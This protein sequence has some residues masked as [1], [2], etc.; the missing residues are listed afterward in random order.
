MNTSNVTA[1]APKVAGA[2]YV[3]PLGTELPKKA[4]T[5]LAPQFKELGYVSDSGMTN[6]NSPSST[7]VKEWGGSTV[8]TATSEKPDNFKF[9]LLEVLSVDV[10]K[11]VYGSNNIE[12]LEDGTIVV[13]AKADDPEELVWVFDMILKGGALKRIV[14]PDAKISSVGDIVYI[15]SDATGYDL[16]I[17]AYP[18]KSGDTHTEYIKKKTATSGGASTEKP[19]QREEPV[20][21]EEAQG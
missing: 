7:D 5:D 4:D 3:A 6:S 14:V 19:V 15:R 12:I 20:Q 10:L 17:T 21:N 18:D 16:T 2:V 8:L 1:A 11:T 9:K 13:H